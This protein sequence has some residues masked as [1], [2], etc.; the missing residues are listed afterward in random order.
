MKI[1]QLNAPV[2]FLNGT[3]G[4]SGPEEELFDLFKEIGTLPLLVEDLYKHPENLLSLKANNVKTL[5]IQTTGNNFQDINKAIEFFDAMHFVPEN[6]ILIF[7][8][9]LW[10]TLRDFQEDHPEVNTYEFRSFRFKGDD[11][12]EVLKFRS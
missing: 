9:P 6:V 7:P 3:I 2:A 12:I 11:L 10:C 5:C 4:L 1:E 8:E